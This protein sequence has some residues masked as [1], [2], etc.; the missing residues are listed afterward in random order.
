MV[1][2][3]D[4]NANHGDGGDEWG[5]DEMRWDER[6]DE[7][8]IKKIRRKRGRRGRRGRKGKGGKDEKEREGDGRNEDRKV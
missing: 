7:Q 5:G 6:T 1:T 3:D 4:N 2:M 8:M